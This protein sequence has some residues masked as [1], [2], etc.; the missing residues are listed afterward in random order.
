LI[1]FA[2]IAAKPLF[3]KKTFQRRKR[4]VLVCDTVE[5]RKWAGGFLYK[6]EVQRWGRSGQV[7]IRTSQARM[8]RFASKMTI[9]G[10]IDSFTTVV[11]NSSKHTGVVISSCP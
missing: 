8:G 9:I 10:K 11:F 5:Q 2:F 1:T 4:L 6:S 7:A 3:S